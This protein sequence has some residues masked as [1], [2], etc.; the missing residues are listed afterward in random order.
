M[1]RLILT[2]LALILSLVLGRW[3]IVRAN[4]ET[5]YWSSYLNR[6]AADLQTLRA[7]AGGNPVLLFSGGSSCAFSI[8]PPVITEVT[9]WPAMNLGGH[10]GTGP[11]FLA[12][13]ALEQAKSG[14]VVILALEPELLTSE[15][16]GIVSQVGV[17]LAADLGR[18]ELAAGAPVFPD[19]LSWR[20]QVT[21]LRPG[22][23]YFAV[24][25]AK[26]LSGRSAYRYTAD[27][28]RPGGRME[29]AAEDRVTAEPL[30][31]AQVK[32][33]EPGKRFLQNAAAW[34]RERGIRLFYAM[35]WKL[36]VREAVAPNRANH[37][38]LLDEISGII[39]VIR[40]A[41]L[42]SEEDTSFF[43]DTYYHLTAKAAALRSRELA[44]ALRPVLGTGAVP[45]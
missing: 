26:K 1:K 30:L 3:L 17:A 28:Y 44:E 42:G 38:V 43:S 13:W 39:P 37:A 36:T 16:A 10:A 45:P 40:D 27:D 31:P 41:H 6:K 7:G 8:D 23:Q 35:P 21:F 29:T 5:A 9:G 20:E 2:G 15:E 19:I 33:S 18:P 11:R 12:A 22:V 14:D 24:T 25:G 4:P 32:L 34:T